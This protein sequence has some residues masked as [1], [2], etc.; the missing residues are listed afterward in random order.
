MYR[1][2]NISTI[3]IKQTCDTGSFQ[4]SGRIENIYRLGGM[5]TAMNQNE[6]IKDCK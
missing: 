6:M 2:K 1:K 5:K 4:L 3:N